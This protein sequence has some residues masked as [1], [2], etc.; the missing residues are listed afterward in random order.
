MNCLKNLNID[1]LGFQNEK[2]I[3]Y[4]FMTQN[5]YFSH[6]SVKITSYQIITI[7]QDWV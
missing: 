7:L 3:S 1:I 5:G 6:R 4:T 2:T